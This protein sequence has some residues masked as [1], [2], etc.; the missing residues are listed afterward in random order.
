MRPRPPLSSVK[1]FWNEHPLAVDA[2][3]AEAGTPAF[4]EQYDQLREANEP[5]EF[6]SELHEYAAFK[7]KRVLEVGMGN[8]YTLSRYCQ[9]GAEVFG[10]DITERAV[11]IA[12]QR[13][14]LLGLH[15]DFQIGN[16]EA[17][18]YPDAHF[19]CICSMG[20]LHHVPDTELAVREIHRCLKPDGRLIV[21]FYHKDSLTYR[22]KMPVE[23]L[24]QGKS[25]QQR[26]NEVDGVGNPKGDVYSR[27]ELREL[28]SEFKELE[29]STRVLDNGKRLESVLPRRLTE[30]LERRVGW[31][32]YMKG[33]K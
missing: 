1:N 2:I 14:Q 23:A 3:S 19:D 9:E 24:L 28:F 15:G 10:I 29:F 33:R 31:F 18:P 22:L 6:A 27:Q 5:R 21:M 20:V 30:I 17:L 32:L 11:Q 26:V 7:G 25:L 12:R 4:F 13:F 8:A 16:A